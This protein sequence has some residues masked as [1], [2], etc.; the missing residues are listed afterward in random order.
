[1]TTSDAELE[2][3]LR[4]AYRLGN[5]PA[6]FAAL[7]TVFRH[8]DAAGNTRFAFR[9]RLNA[10]HDLHHCGEYTR[11]FMAFSWC[12]TTFDRH[13][14]VT[15]PDDE[16]SLLWRFK[17][18][19]WELSQFP[20]VPLDRTVALLDDMQRRYQAG[21]HSL[22]AVY[23]HRGLVAVHLGD[24]PAAG[25][26]FEEMVTARRDGLSDCRHCVP[27]SHVSYLVAAGRF[28]EAIDVG[29][30]YTSGGCTEQPQWMLSELLSAYLHTSA[31]QVVSCTALPGL[32]V[33]NVAKRRMR[34]ARA[35]IS[36][37]VAVRASSS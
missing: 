20:A 25:H 11:A 1:M 9:A 4:A 24:L 8:A 29:T 10:L 19:V 6:K 18:I 3:M 17:W 22:H 16:H 12:L 15:A 5:G 33:R 2:E 31:I 37:Q 35:V 28:E 30:P 21:G 36:G 13:P 26:W 34:S 14:E 7:D 23:Q 27:S 32:G